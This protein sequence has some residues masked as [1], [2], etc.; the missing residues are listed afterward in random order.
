MHLVVHREIPDNERLRHQWNDL[1]LQM[2][3]PEVFYTH[4]WAS[5]AYKAYRIQMTPLLLLAYEK[6]SLVGVVALATDPAQ[7][8]VF[9]TSTT[10]D[11]C[12]FVCHP[13]RRAEF[14]DSVFAELRKMNAGMLRLAN[15]PADSATSGALNQ[16]AH[17]HGYSIFSRPAY[18]CA[19]VVI[20]SPESR[21]AVKES[22][23]RRMRRY[24]K[25]LG[26]KATVKFIHSRSIDEIGIELPTFAKA[27][28]ARFLA[29]GRISNL[30]R[31]E[32][33]V[34]LD[35]LAS[36]LSAAGW[37]TLSRLMVG[38]QTVA[39]NYGFQFGGSWFWYQPTFATDF[40]Q[41]SPGLWLLSKIVEESCE[42]TELSRIDLGLGAEGY[43]ERLATASRQTLHVTATTSALGCWKERIRY[44]TAAAI[45]SVPRLEAWVR[46]GM[47]FASSLKARL[48]AEGLSGYIRNSLRCCQRLLSDESE[49]F[50][51]AWSQEEFLRMR[52]SVPYSLA[53]QPV[54]LDL[55]AIAVMHYVEE[56]ETLAYLLR[57][58]DRLLSDESQGFALVTSEGVP[59]HFCW[60]TN[61]EEFVTTELKHPMTAPSSDCVLIVDCWTPASVRGQGYYREAIANVASR[62]HTARKSPWILIS[63]AN[64]TALGGSEKTGFVR[65]FSLLDKRLLFT[66]KVVESRCSTVTRPVVEVSSA[67]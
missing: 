18:A 50:F 60:V 41:Y 26:K 4:E 5:A 27:H 32:R 36:S 64:G 1:V 2:E 63:A 34:F 33:R 66:R 40:Q 6:D 58:V 37:F 12:D 38:T 35:E 53:I 61:F 43:K 42:N 62:L 8:T 15:L 49:F 23:Q 10:A 47:G 17:N 3:R 29:T 9:L 45:Q 44:H 28:V 30:A 21:A 14:L 24:N 67:A 25:A 7:G 20:D 31:P 55:L 19:Q 57:A 48:R 16:A 39:W 54:D 11:Y 22:V 52:H 59:L 46:S 13:Q 65:M 51:L 56:P